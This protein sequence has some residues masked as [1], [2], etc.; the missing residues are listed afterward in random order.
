MFGECRIFVGHHWFIPFRSNVC[1]QPRE[2]KVRRPFIASPIWKESTTIFRSAPF[3]PNWWRKVCF[4]IFSRV[5]A[6]TLYKSSI[7]IH[8]YFV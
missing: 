5:D 1:L 6:E 2:P 8:E 7:H 3:Q 4:R